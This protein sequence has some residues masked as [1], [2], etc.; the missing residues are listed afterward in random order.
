M[1]DKKLDNIRIESFT[2]LI[3]P[4]EIRKQIPL[5]PQ[6]TETIDK[7][8]SDFCSILNNEDNRFVVIV[9]PCSIHDP[10]AAIE[11]AE[12]LQKLNEE[13]SDKLLIMMRVYFEK[14]RTTTGWK[15]F[16]NDPFLNKTCDME[17]GIK[18]ARQLLVDIADLGLPTATELLD[19]IT[20]A[21]IGEMVS[22]AAIGARTTESQTHRQM[23]SGLSA[24]IGFKNNSDGNL[25][26]AVN[27]MK[28]AKSSH[29]FLGIDDEGNCS[30]LKTKGNHATHIILRG[31]N[32]RPNYHREDIEECE[33]KLKKSESQLKIMVDCSH[34]NSG[35]NHEKQHFVIK[36]IIAQKQEGNQSIFGLMIE[37]N[38]GP[39]N[40]KITENI[41]DLEYGVSVTDACI[42][43]EETEDLL[44]Q[45]HKTF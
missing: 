23:T 36:D 38:L 13:L 9:G 11:Y 41:D 22:W 19:P 40:Q 4:S 44:R 27:A 3:S 34:E 35:K 14:P 15:G 37:S 33:A 6:A 2:K 1:S 31:G 28:S 10:K 32:G 5:S 16:I 12:K 17:A 29:S 43:W 20:A 39:G 7:G 24:P 42:G 26:I 30:I 8:R 21:Y 18:L 45:L 25:D